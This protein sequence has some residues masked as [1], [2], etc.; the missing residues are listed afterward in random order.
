MHR[1]LKGIG[2]ERVAVQTSFLRCKYDLLGTRPNMLSALEVD[3][4]RMAVLAAQILDLEN[5]ESVSALHLE[6]A[7]VQ[8][9]L[10]SYKYPVLTLPNEIVAEIFF[11]IPPPYPAVPS[12]S[13]I[14]SLTSL[15]CICRRWRGIATS[16]SSLWRAINLSNNGIPSK[17]RM[18]IYKLWLNRSRSRPLSIEFDAGEYEFAAVSKVMRLIAPH[19]SRWERLKLAIL[20]IDIHFVEGGMPLLQHLDLVVTGAFSVKSISF[21]E[22]PLLRSVVL[23]GIA[24]KHAK[25]GLPW[26]QL[27]SLDLRGLEIEKCTPILS[28]TSTLV[29][30]ELGLVCTCPVIPSTVTVPCLESLVLKV[31]G[32]RYPHDCQYLKFFITPTLRRLTIPEPFLGKDPVLCLK[33]FILKSAAQLQEV[34]ITGRRLVSRESYHDALQPVLELSFH[35]GDSWNID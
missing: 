32:H 22:L 15:A 23:N 3:R 7:Q 4:A 1:N 10:D 26:A 11:H 29:H 8:S 34:R 31:S 13:E 25:L 27:T 14:R 12:P 35:G 2:V 6:Q 24:F 33:D 19:R 16:M 9:R 20:I 21:G 18:H 5:S 30:C 17:Q 28:Q